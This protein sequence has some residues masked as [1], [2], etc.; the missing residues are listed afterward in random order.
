MKLIHVISVWKLFSLIESKYIEH[1]QVPIFTVKIHE[2]L[3]YWK[4][5]K[6]YTV[7]TKIQIS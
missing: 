6:Y 7:I 5:N 3:G 4:I 2:I 1:I